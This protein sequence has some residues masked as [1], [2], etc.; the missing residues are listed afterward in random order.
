MGVRSGLGGVARLGLVLLLLGAPVAACGDTTPV[1]LRSPGVAYGSPDATPDKVKTVPA[2]DRDPVVGDTVPMGDAGG[3]ATVSATDAKV[4]AGRLFAPG[5][6]KDYYAVLVKACSGPSEQ[7]LS[8][9]RHYFTLEMADKTV[10]DTGPGVK[11]PDLTGGEV[12]AGG[13]LEGWITF[14]VPEA[15][16]RG[17]SK[18][19]A[20]PAFVVYDGS[21]QVKWA[22]PAGSPQ[23]AAR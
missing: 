6:G 7:G 15:G 17:V 14:V 13:C 21:R 12:P 16:A 4:S 23:K 18:P 20:Q 2:L 9:K 3:S 1:Q 11:K 8:F 5:K 10:H 19:S 22:I